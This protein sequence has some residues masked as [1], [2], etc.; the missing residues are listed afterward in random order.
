MSRFPTDVSALINSYLEEYYIPD[1]IGDVT[2]CSSFTLN[3]HPKAIEILKENPEKINVDYIAWNRNPDSKQLESL[4]EINKSRIFRLI[5]S[6][7]W[8]DFALFFKGTPCKK[9][10]E[11][12]HGYD[13]N[14]IR[15]NITIIKQDYYDVLAKN[16]NIFV[17]YDYTKELNLL[18]WSK[19]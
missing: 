9:I 8:S 19:I 6:D 13:L 15:E 14:V 12:C 10:W 11:I 5:H 1:W 16:P 17:L 7:G 2:K 4:V 3:P 18:E